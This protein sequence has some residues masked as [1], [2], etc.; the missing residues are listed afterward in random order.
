MMSSLTYPLVTFVLLLVCVAYWGATAVY[1]WIFFLGKMLIPKS[2]QHHLRIH[3]PVLA[4]LNWYVQILGNFRRARLQS[5]G[6]KFHQYWLWDYQRHCDLWPSG[7]NTCYLVFFA[8]ISGYNFSSNFTDLCFAFPVRLSTHQ[9]TLHALQPAASLST[10]TRRVSSRGTCSTCRFT[11]LLLS[12]GVWTLSS[13]WGSARW[14]GPSPP[15]TGPTTNQATS[16]HFQSVPALCVLSGM[17]M[18]W[19][20]VIQVSAPKKV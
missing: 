4:L 14:R 19:S 16:P 5:C 6:F 12:C 11:M 3:I 13:P 2:A 18:S 15:I 1:P 20:Q 9:N 7:W 17:Q 10:T 8:V